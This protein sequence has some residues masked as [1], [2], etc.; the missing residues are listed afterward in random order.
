MAVDTR[1]KRFS[2]L[3]LGNITQPVVL[4]PDGTLD[5]SDRQH[6]LWGYSGIVWG[7]PSAAVGLLCVDISGTVPGIGM[8]SFIP[9]IDITSTSPSIGITS[10]GDCI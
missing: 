8:T 10:K 6:L 5:Q 2:I 1:Q 7:V 9:G 3:T 4:T